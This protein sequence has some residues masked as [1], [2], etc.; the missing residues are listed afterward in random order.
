MVYVTRPLHS[1]SPLSLFPLLSNFVSCY[2]FQ[3]G[4]HARN[5]MNTSDVARAYEWGAVEFIPN[6]YNPVNALTGIA[7]EAGKI[8]TLFRF[9]K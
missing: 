5:R 1:K 2:G 9:E 8:P 7:I 6:P 4:A 3:R